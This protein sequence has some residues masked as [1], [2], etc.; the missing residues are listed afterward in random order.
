[1]ADMIQI[2]SFNR[3]GREGTQRNSLACRGFV[4]DLEGVSIDKKPPG[5]VFRASP[6]GVRRR[7]A[8]NNRIGLFSL[9]F[10]ASF[11]VKQRFL[12]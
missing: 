3:K 5:T 2:S 8:P 4:P 10:F 9:A 12:G 7:D 6:V 1:M 11:A